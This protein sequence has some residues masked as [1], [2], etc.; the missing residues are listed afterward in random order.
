MVLIYKPSKIKLAFVLPW[1]LYLG[2][3]LVLGRNIIMPVSGLTL[4]FLYLLGGCAEYMAELW[5]KLGNRNGL[6]MAAGILAGLDQL[7]KL[8]V[9]N[10]LPLGSRIVLI[11]GSFHLQQALNMEA[12][13]LPN[14]FGFPVP[15]ALLATAAILV[16]LA[17]LAVYNYYVGVHR[18]N[19]YTDLA[20]V[21]IFAGA[22]SALGD[23]IMRG[24]TV[25]FI[26]FQGFFVADLKDIYLTLG[27]AGGIA[28]VLI[29]PAGDPKFKELPGLI[30]KIFRYN[31][32]VCKNR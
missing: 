14:K 13:W 11:P 26:A 30:V 22:L 10:Y 18:Q 9:L 24:Y 3:E 17:S 27:L 19:V 8:A 1:L 5:G 12:A 25:D 31:L 28:E 7:F 21:L 15:M 29:S 6:L 16:I 32:K 4:L 2:L 23:Q 20:L